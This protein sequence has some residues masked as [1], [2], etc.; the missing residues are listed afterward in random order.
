MNAKTFLFVCKEFFDQINP[1]FME[2]EDESD[3]ENN[4][5]EEEEMHREII[6][7]IDYFSDLFNSI[8]SFM[9]YKKNKLE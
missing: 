9:S 6:K 4:K 1:N 2:D 5:K 3:I 7:D 8:F